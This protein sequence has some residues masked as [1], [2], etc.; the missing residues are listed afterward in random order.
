MQFPST[1]WLWCK[2]S[3]MCFQ[4]S[5]L[6]QESNNISDIIKST[7]LMA[8][9]AGSNNIA[10]ISPDLIPAAGCGDPQY[11]KLIS[12]IQQS[13]PRTRNLMARKVREYWEVRHRLSINNSLVLLD[14]R[15]V[16]PKTQWR[17][18]MHCLHSAHQGVIGM[19]ACANKSVYWPGMSALICSIRANCMVCSNI[20][21]SQ[22][23]EPIIFT[24]SL[25]WPFQ[26]IV[27]D[28]FYIRDHTY[29]AYTDS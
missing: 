19:K 4:Q 26:Q 15:I 14:Q 20:A 25:D 2:P 21:P 22:P 8:T 11:G 13:F 6:S 12:V 10:M 29:L 3:S 17:K 28:F 16:I 7:A 23:L 18:V 27:M 5:H 9:F 1:Q 24:Q